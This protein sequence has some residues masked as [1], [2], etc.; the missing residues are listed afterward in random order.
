M[1]EAVFS[2][3]VEMGATNS[4]LWLVR[5]G[6]LRYVGGAGV[7]SVPEDIAA[8]P[9]DADLPGPQSVRD[10]AIITFGSAEERDRRWPSLIGLPGQAFATAV[11]PL[12]VGE[13]RLGCLHIGYPRRMGPADFDLDFLEGLAEL[14]AAA[15]DR[16]QMHD[17]ERARQTLLLEASRAVAHAGSFQQALVRLAEVAVPD[18]ADLCLID[19]WEERAIRRMAAV[20]ADPA[21]AELVRELGDRYP[22]QPGSPHPGAVVIEE[23]RSIYATEIPSGF[24]RRIARSPHHLEVAEQLGVES[25]MSVPLMVAGEILGAITLVSA[26]S[27]RRFGPDDLRLAEDLAG[28]VTDVVFS[29]RQN[30]RQHE[31]AH[32]LQRLLLP[33]ALPEVAGVE[34]SA[35][36]LTARRD[37]EAGGDFY[38]VVVLPSGRL[39]F[40]IGDVEGHDP[41]AAAIMGQLRSALRALAG[42]H[43]EP[44]A[45]MDALRWSW[46][47]LG[48]SRMATCLI[49]RLDPDDGSVVAC[50]AGHPP[51][52]LIGPAGDVH[53]VEVATSPPLGA[54]SGPS[55]ETR[56]TIGGGRTLFLYTD[57]LVETPD[58]NIDRGLDNLLDLLRSA[59][60]LDLDE[61]C[62]KVLANRPAA[63]SPDDIAMLALRL[64]A[65][66]PENAAHA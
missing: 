41:V 31:L 52:V 17:A 4:G 34:V 36:Y 53:L 12:V 7:A 18:L 58:L 21:V 57:G 56:L 55:R 29:A 3:L 5:A 6:T 22:P 47:L 54:P 62:D 20:H 39:G 46:D 45:L 50:S 35:R 1:A 19:I 49:G 61:M 26:G 15:L 25:Y 28:Q 64:G 10:N 48:F 51:P 33:E 42:Q 23:G 13:R 66:P 59:H 27:G 38:D 11:L 44:H 63:G 40:V 9:L 14:G 43:R 2:R 8:M 60:G 16:A 30:E 32:Q 37:A 24:L 65:S